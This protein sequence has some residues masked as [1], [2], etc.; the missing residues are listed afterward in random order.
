M[1]KSELMSLPQ[2][3]HIPDDN[4]DHEHRVIP[5]GPRFQA[6]LPAPIE[7]ES[8]TSRWLGT[9]VWPLKTMIRNKN[10][11]AVGRGRTD[12]CNCQ[13]PRSSEC[14]KRHVFEQ[15]MKLQ[16][17]FGLAFNDWK[18]DQMGEEAAKSWT[19]EERKKIESIVKRS[20]SFM[21]LALK[22][23]PNLSRESIVN[24]YFNI[25]VPRKIGSKTRAG[26]LPA[27]ISTDNDDDEMFSRHKR[28]RVS[29]SDCSNRTK[30]RSV[31]ESEAVGRRYL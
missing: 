13:V 16:K 5:I 18:F 29:C 23:L 12:I 28:T 22:A 21:D 19:L 1:K 17:E 26:F 31:D 9:V 2:Y 30:K 24:Y 3:L 27:D 7:N 14:V 25:I 20:K 10:T 4:P 15:K 11:I 6:E 8:D